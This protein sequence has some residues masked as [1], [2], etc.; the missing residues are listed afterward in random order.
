[1]VSKCLVQLAILFDKCLWFIVKRV[2]TAVNRIHKLQC[3]RYLTICIGVICLVTLLDRASQS[4]LTHEKV[5]YLSV[6]DDLK[7]CDDSL[8]ETVGA[9]T[10]QSKKKKKT[11]L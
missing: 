3:S 2:F 1:M 9:R 4:A 6:R 7:H 10:S 8:H 11:L 5:K